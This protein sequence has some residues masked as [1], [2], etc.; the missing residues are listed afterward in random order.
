MITISLLDLFVFCASLIVPFL[1]AFLF[2]IRQIEK[3][4]QDDKARYMFNFIAGVS[5]VNSSLLYIIAASSAYLSLYA[6]A[7]VF[8][9]IASILAL[10]S[11]V[12]L[13]GTALRA[14][15]NQHTLTAP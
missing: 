4:N 1:F 13:G 2:T 6:I 15:Q 10:G 14:K 8:A 11:A 3:Y 12:L 7:I 9:S 5:L